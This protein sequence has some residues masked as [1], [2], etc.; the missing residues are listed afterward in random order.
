LNEKLVFSAGEE[1]GLSS[2]EAYLADRY[3]HQFGRAALGRTGLL[4]RTT[5]DA[6]LQHESECVLTI[7]LARLNQDEQV[8]ASTPDCLASDLLPPLRPGDTDVDHGVDSGA[9]VVMDAEN[10][11]VLSLV[12]EAQLER[13]MAA[14]GQPFIYL[15]AFAEGYSPG[16]MV[17]DLPV[18]ADDPSELSGLDTERFHGP[19]RI[20]TALANGY[21]AAADKMV[22][23]VGV[24]SVLSIFE[25]MG[26]SVSR[27]VDAGPGGWQ[28][29]LVDLVHAS[30][31]FANNG[32]LTGYAAGQGSDSVETIAFLDIVD[33]AGQLLYAAQP[34]RKAVL[35]EQL[36][37]LVNDVLSDE[38]ERLERLGP[39]NPLD[40]NRTAAATAAVS[41]GGR[42]A[43]AL[44]YTP[45]R[46]VGIWLGSPSGPTPVDLTIRNG[47]A[48]V[49]H[50]LMIYATRDLP[51]E[52]WPLP[53]GVTRLEVCD[54]SG[55]LPTIYCPETVRELFISGTEPTT[56]DNLFQPYLVNKE[57]GKLATLSTPVELV[58][59]R[60]YLVPP[61]EALAWASAVGIEQPPQEYD[62]LT[63]SG[64]QD[65]DVR[66]S[67]P[68]P[69][70]FLNGVVRVRGYV[71][72]DDLDFYRLQVGKGLNPLNWIQLGEDRS[73][74]V[75]GG[76]LAE[77][78]TSELEGLYTLQLVAVQ[79]EGQVRNALV[80]V[81]IDNEP[82]TGEVVFPQEGQL[83]TG[84]STDELAVQVDA[85]DEF[86]LNRVVFYIDDNEVAEL[87]A[88]PFSFRW[89]MQSS[90]KHEVY[91]ELYDLAGN[92]DVT[93]IVTFE[94]RRP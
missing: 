44:G 23:L 30:S 26:V 42:D 55:L 74:P 45:D 40:V 86:G 13:P 91:A 21:R 83:F 67:S 5:I 53:A 46:V 94:I 28:G 3:I 6:D 92:L 79:D 57:T 81:T 90:G 77:W 15:T 76:I 69:F 33:D 84:T 2:L 71:A 68:A 87:S 4:V 73:L 52:T 27:E 59:E 56:F 10:G 24:E 66:I 11:E 22:E 63:E 78:D 82:P 20:R 75:R 64:A 80:H 39:S 88:E 31:V 54:P 60:V 51:P 85:Q 8:Q 48:P 89:P 14:L 25:T 61:P 1:N 50:A 7:H 18:N 70:E 62:T 35:S 34:V 17:M 72:I 12:G 19:V 37:Y 29:T 49:W 47:A 16:S 38:V 32:V 36:A 58:E 65:P 93:D 41:E 9:L 43:W